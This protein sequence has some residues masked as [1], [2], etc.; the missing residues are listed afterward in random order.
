MKLLTD[1]K[2]RRI[3]AIALFSLEAL[4]LTLFFF[5]GVAKGNTFAIFGA[6]E[7]E[8]ELGTKVIHALVLTMTAVVL[9]LTIRCLMEWLSIQQKVE[10]LIGEKIRK[11]V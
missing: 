10:E 4:F 5:L 2:I 11:E 8:V 6:N 7:L 9:I 3:A 1:F